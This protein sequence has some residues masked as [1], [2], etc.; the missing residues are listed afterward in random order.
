MISKVVPLE[1]GDFWMNKVY[2]RE[3]GL[4]K[5]VFLCDEEQ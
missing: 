2:N 1:E 3:D 4:T 5:I